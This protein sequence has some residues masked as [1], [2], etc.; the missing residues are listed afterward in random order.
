MM[1][2]L[3]VVVCF[4]LFLSSVATGALLYNQNSS[5]SSSTSIPTSS[6]STSATTTLSANYITKGSDK[7]VKSK[8]QNNQTLSDITDMDV[9]CNNDSQSVG[10]QGFDLG[11]TSD[12]TPVLKYDY[13]CANGKNVS[14]G[15]VST[16]SNYPV[17]NAD[18]SNRFSAAE[19]HGTI[20]FDRQNVQCPNDTF[21]NKFKLSQTTSNIYYN[22]V[23]QKIG[24]GYLYDYSCKKSDK[25]MSC[26]TYQTDPGQITD[27][28]KPMQS[29]LAEPVKCPSDSALTQFH[30]TRVIGQNGSSQDAMAYQYTCCKQTN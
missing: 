23:D 5:S 4:C 29:G 9:D 18:G 17:Y 25:P 21:L 30:P 27:G 8:G 24:K 6:S 1:M 20:F 3:A 12:T 26:S 2:I 7:T 10:I 22:G 16:Y 11:L 14:S 28:Y 13:T 15:G 19:L